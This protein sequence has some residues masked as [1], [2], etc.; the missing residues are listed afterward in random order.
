ML[1]NLAI[2]VKY[3]HMGGSLHGSRQMPEGSCMDHITGIAC[4]AI[5]L[6]RQFVITAFSEG[7]NNENSFMQRLDQ[8]R[9][10]PFSE[11][12]FLPFVISMLPDG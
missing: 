6:K 10:T 9:T 12:Q 7:S 1:Q 3:C 8:L 11:Y 5:F 4:S 2:F